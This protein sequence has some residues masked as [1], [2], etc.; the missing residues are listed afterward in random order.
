MTGHGGNVIGNRHRHELMICMPACLPF[1]GVMW[2][3]T[4]LSKK[5]NK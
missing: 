2:L 3:P 4:L 1:Y 5:I